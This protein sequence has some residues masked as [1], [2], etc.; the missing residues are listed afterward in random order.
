MD[1]SAGRPPAVVAAALKSDF[2]VVHEARR[3]VRR[4]WLDTFD[5]R[6]F[7][8]GLTLEHTGHA[9]GGELLLA[10]IAGRQV[11]SSP[12]AG[13]TRP[14]WLNGPVLGAIGDHVASVVGRRAL[15]PVAE[16]AGKLTALRLLNSDDK[17]VVRAVVEE[18]A[19]FST[20]PGR[21]ASRVSITAVRG[22]DRQAQLAQRILLATAGI[23]PSSGSRL[24]EALAAAGRRPGDYTGTVQVT[25]SA[26]AS[27]RSALASVL[28]HVLDVLEANVDG[29]ARDLDVE[30]LH[31]LRIAVRRTRSGLALAGDALPAGL[32]ARFGGEFTWL[33]QLTTPV[34][35]LD[36]CLEGLDA[37]LLDLAP[38]DLDALQPFRYYLARRRQDAWPDLVAGLQSR[39]FA[40]L[41]SE[42]RAALVEVSAQSVEGE[43]TVAQLATARIT[44]GYNRILKP[45]K[46]ITPLSPAED[47]HELRKRCKELRYLLEYFASIHPP[48]AH[49][50]MIKELKS[51][52]DCLGRFQD[53]Q[54]QREA[55]TSLAEQ[56]AGE[57][58]PPPETLR[59]M[60]QLAA[61]LDLQQAEAR[62]EF[63][64][65]F[66]RFAGARTIG[67]LMALAEPTTT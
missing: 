17:T 28:L 38:K 36:A 29:V 50:A 30:F 54:I 47:L 48:A 11:A 12:A 34:R 58:T 41:L 66:K 15:L 45:G 40:A 22:Y 31:D 63:A 61:N 4:T 49:R 46:A 65:R 56:I 59:V 44:R 25:L 8:A 23:A 14:A 6:L 42:W 39:R 51:L 57:L 33:S 52:Q 62:N 2:V 26:S 60:D 37:A 13:A 20:V 21:L 35:D 32:A 24:A 53:S 64:G 67:V 55:I 7:R 1:D 9:E 10:T 43:R 3:T 18:N 27:A 16:T 19:L 5:W